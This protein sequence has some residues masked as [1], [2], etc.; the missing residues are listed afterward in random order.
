MEANSEKPTSS[1]G[2]KPEATKTDRQDMWDTRIHEVT[3]IGTINFKNTARDPDFTHRYTNNPIWTYIAYKYCCTPDYRQQPRKAHKKNIKIPIDHD[4]GREIENAMLPDRDYWSAT[5][6]RRAKDKGYTFTTNYNNDKHVYSNK[7]DISNNLSGQEALNLLKELKD[8]KTT[9]MVWRETTRHRP[10][11]ALLPLLLW[12]NPAIG[13]NTSGRNIT[14][15]T[16]QLMALTT[17]YLVL[18][19][20]VQYKESRVTLDLRGTVFEDIV[21]STPTI[22]KTSIM[23]LAMDISKHLNPEVLYIL[24]EE[25]AHRMDYEEEYQEVHVAAQ[26][27]IKIMSFTNYDISVMLEAAPKWLLYTGTTAWTKNYRTR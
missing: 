11:A 4:L 19:K 14:I 23:E 2:A 24:R 8:M 3:D 9:R 26:A 16:Q 18:H 25:E 6:C 12:A 22:T 20:R 15:S 27:L 7:I 1:N 10:T 17:L 5:S 21:T 13:A